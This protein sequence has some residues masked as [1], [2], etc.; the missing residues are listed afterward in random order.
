MSKE[1]R[2]H[3]SQCIIYPLYLGLRGYTHQWFMILIWD[4]IMSIKVHLMFYVIHQMEKH[5]SI[6]IECFLTL[7]MNLETLGWGY[8]VI[9]SFHFWFLRHNIHVDQYLL[10]HIISYLSYVWQVNICSWH[11]LFQVQTVQ[12]IWLTYIC[13]LWSMS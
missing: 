8:A 1:R 11:A 7:L 13:S 5:G 4:G 12:K 6:F 3:L 9:D 10:R 2:F